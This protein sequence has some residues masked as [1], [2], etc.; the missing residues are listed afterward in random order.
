MKVVITRVKSR[1]SMGYLGSLESQSRGES[2]RGV[3]LVRFGV[4]EAWWRVECVCYTSLSPSYFD[5][6]RSGD[7]I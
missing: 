1:R 3:T 6:K 2:S 7:D 5:V 4:G